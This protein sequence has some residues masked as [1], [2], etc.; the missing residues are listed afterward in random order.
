MTKSATRVARA[1]IRCGLNHPREHPPDESDAPIGSRPPHE[2]G[3][4]T[5]PGKRPDVFN[6]LLNGLPAPGAGG[7]VEAEQQQLGQPR[8]GILG[9]LTLTPNL[10]E[11]TMVDSQAMDRGQG[12]PRSKRSLDSGWMSSGSSF[13]A[14]PRSTTSRRSKAWSFFLDVRILA[15]YT[16]QKVSE[17]RGG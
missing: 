4:A 1:R 2:S 6:R 17:T 16:H 14:P 9:R 15:F 7:I 10:G 5:L 13:K 12:D 3:S 11:I 8:G